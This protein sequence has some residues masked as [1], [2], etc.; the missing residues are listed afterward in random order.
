MTKLI[1]NWWNRSW[2][3]GSYIKLC[4]ASIVLVV[5]IVGVWLMKFYGMFEKIGNWF[6]NLI[7]RNDYYEQKEAE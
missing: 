4:I 3:N 1:K 7:H 5:V 2:T 6:R